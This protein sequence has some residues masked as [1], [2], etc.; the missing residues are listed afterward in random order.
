M[1]ASKCH[2]K[3]QSYAY[4]DNYSKIIFSTDLFRR[5]KVPKESRWFDHVVR[6]CFAI[7]AADRP[8]CEWVLKQLKIIENDSTHDTVI[9]IQKNNP[10]SDTFLYA[11]W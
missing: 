8:S 2:I 6:A 5:L 7:K 1:C 10:S 3:L 9:D 11:V 4:N